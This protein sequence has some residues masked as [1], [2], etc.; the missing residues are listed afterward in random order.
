LDF[1]GEDLVCPAPGSTEEADLITIIEGIVGAP[2]EMESCTPVAAAGRRLLAP[3]E[4]KIVFRKALGEV[5][6]S[7]ADSTLALVESQLAESANT[8]AAGTKCNQFDVF[9]S[10]SA[11]TSVTDNADAAVET[12]TGAPSSAPTP[13]PT[14]APTTT[15]PT[16]S[17]TNSPTLS[18]GNPTRAPTEA[19]ATFSPTGAPTVTP[20]TRPTDNPTASPTIP[21]RLATGSIT[22]TDATSTCAAACSADHNAAGQDCTSYDPI[23]SVTDSAVEATACSAA[24]GK[25]TISYALNVGAVGV[26]DAVRLA[27]ALVKDLEADIAAV[28]TE[29]DTVFGTTV[30]EARVNSGNI[31]TITPS[32]SAAPTAGPTDV[33]A[34]PTTR[35]STIPVVIQAEIKPLT[36]LGADGD[37]EFWAILTW[38]SPLKVT[39]TPKVVLSAHQTFDNNEVDIDMDY[40]ESCA[41]TDLANGVMCFKNANADDLCPG[42]CDDSA[43]NAAHVTEIWFKK[44]EDVDL[45]TGSI[46]ED[47]DG[48][49]GDDVELEWIATDVV[50][51]NPDAQGVGLGAS[52]DNPVIIIQPAEVEDDDSIN[53]LLDEAS[54]TDKLSLELT[55]DQGLYVNTASSTPALYLKVLTSGRTSAT[56]NDDNGDGQDRTEFLYDSCA[57][58]CTVLTF[59]ATARK[60][61][62]GIQTY[63]ANGNTAE[64][65]AS[66]DNTGGVVASNTIAGAFVT[67]TV[68][69][70]I[71]STASGGLAVIQPL[72]YVQNS[73]SRGAGTN[74][75]LYANYIIP[76][77]AAATIAGVEI[78]DV[79]FTTNVPTV[80]SA[81]KTPS[82]GAFQGNTLTMSVTYDEAMTVTGTPTLPM[83]NDGSYSDSTLTLSYDAA[84]SKSKILVFSAVVPILASGKA[85]WSVAAL[86]TDEPGTITGGTIVTSADAT[87]SFQFWEYVLT[88]GEP[89]ASAGSAL[90]SALQFGPTITDA[91][92][93]TDGNDPGDF[94]LTV[95]YS[96][97]VRFTG[98]AAG[99]TATSKFVAVTK[100]GGTGADT[101]DDLDCAQ[102]SSSSDTVEC[103]SATTT[104]VATDT[105]YLKPSSDADYSVGDS[106]TWNI[107]DAIECDGGGA[108]NIGDCDPLSAGYNGAANGG[109]GATAQ[110][111]IP[112]SIVGKGADEDNMY[113]FV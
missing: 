102:T 52:D 38:D 88:N 72:T 49:D 29:Y 27:D 107:I 92:F 87:P 22:F 4:L 109:D 62:G 2:V 58:S 21:E 91:V 111:Y 101:D 15:K 56:N 16:G 45:N 64:V 41:E 43:A 59:I 8:D 85:A 97:K 28:I 30:T 63:F 96:G 25:V 57:T 82:E 1:A 47:I 94:V 51:S 61:A 48:A 37:S 10:G 81:Y 9:G 35:Q 73:N 110:D 105:A 39:G 84:E 6:D 19:G 53:F 5:S 106:A 11:V 7:L 108:A 13:K 113:E 23:V 78:T 14:S 60:T 40:D 79:T 71:A 36:G 98:A 95:T 68:Q 55:F 65:Q 75:G 32:P 80:S 18:T 89:V 42:A 83:Y 31:Q 24:N 104:F 46:K 3:V 76:T 12:Y 20:T 93:S 74:A 69:A 50:I 34:A 67:N 99:G 70:G 17:P 66:T 54:G 103:T 26:A 33:T 77:K 112:L 86:E 100:K 90:V 44:D